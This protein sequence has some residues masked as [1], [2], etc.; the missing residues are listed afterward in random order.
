MDLPGRPGGERA[1]LVGAAEPPLLQHV[2]RQSRP[3][4]PGAARRRQVG[5]V[6]P[7]LGESP[8]LVDRQLVAPDVGG[9]IHLEEHVRQGVFPPHDG[10]VA[11]QPG[12]AVQIDGLVGHQHLSRPSV[13]VAL[14]QVDRAG[15]PDARARAPGRGASA[16]RS[17]VG[18]EP[19]GRGRRRERPTPSPSRPT[20]TR[21]ARRRPRRRPTSPGRRGSQPG[22]SGLASRYRIVRGASVFSSGPLASW[23]CGVRHAALR[24]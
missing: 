3:E 18:E 10:R 24:V 23:W 2:D 7:H 14:H 16:A 9:V 20:S 22:N 12:L 1:A 21:C 8:G 15:A 19:R 5:R 13:P 11:R 6:H 4:S 17:A